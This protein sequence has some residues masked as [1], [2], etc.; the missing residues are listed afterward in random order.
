VQVS[1]AGVEKP[2][3]I[4]KP[5]VVPVACPIGRPSM[6]SHGQPRTYP[7]KADLGFGRSRSRPINPDK[8][9]ITLSQPSHRLYAASPE[10]SVVNG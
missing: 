4:W 10:S 9:A 3:A 2:I 8:E 6:V 1:A 7:S 5:L